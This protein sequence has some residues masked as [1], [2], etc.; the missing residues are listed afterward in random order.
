[1][2]AHLTIALLQ[3]AYSPQVVVGEQFPGYARPLPRA[4]RTT[5]RGVSPLDVVGTTSAT[6]IS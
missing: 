6:G 3:R 4:I 2:T 5:S 1:M